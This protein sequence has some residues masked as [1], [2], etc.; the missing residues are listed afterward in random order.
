MA[1]A[2]ALLVATPG[3]AGDKKN[4]THASIGGTVIGPE[5]KPLGDVEIRAMKVD[6]KKAPVT[7]VVTNSKGMYMLKSLPVGAY[8]LTAYLDGFEYSRAIIKTQG[9]AWAK[10]DF[11]LRLV[12]GDGADK[13]QTYIRSINVV[14]GNMH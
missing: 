13:I 3:F 14:N 12:A 5:G 10:V 6:D 11:D 7:A 9:V 2:A 1:V 4:P 8:S